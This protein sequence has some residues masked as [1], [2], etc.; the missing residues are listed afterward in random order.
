MGDEAPAVWQGKVH[1]KML[2]GKTLTISAQSDCTVVWLKEQL[3]LP[4]NAGVPI[5]SQRLIFRSKILEED[6]SSLLASGIGPG[7]TVM[8]LGNGREHRC[9]GN[10]AKCAPQLFAPPSCLPCTRDED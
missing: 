9:L 3:Q 5:R 2:T 4:H 6:Q 10:C 8:L 1:I 7:G